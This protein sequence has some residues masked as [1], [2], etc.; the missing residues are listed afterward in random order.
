MQSSGVGNCINML[1]LP[2]NC[3]DA[4]L[5]ADHDAWRVGRVQSVAGADG[6]Q[7]RAGADRGRGAWC[8]WAEHKDEV[9][10]MVAASA[11]FAFDSQIPVAGAPRSA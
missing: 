9:V 7:H 3:R 6:R 1:S 8:A 11:R 2:I 10:D 5:R 4:V